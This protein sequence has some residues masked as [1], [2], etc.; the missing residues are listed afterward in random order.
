MEQ[1][2]N[3]EELLSRRGF[4][5]QA[6]KKTLPILGALAVS[7]IPGLAFAKKETPS[8]CAACNGTCSTGCDGSCYRGC[9]AG[10]R[11][12]C[13]ETC[14]GRCVGTCYQ[15]CMTSCVGGSSGQPSNSDRLQWLRL[16]MFRLMHQLHGLLQWKL[17]RKLLQYLSRNL[18]WQ[19]LSMFYVLRQQL[20]RLL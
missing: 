1:N 18:F 10:C 7:S 17:W 5:R 8:G 13:L 20:F 14:K 12:S 15:G 4:F 9:Q 16:N 2:N 6:V 3:N 19:L 11:G